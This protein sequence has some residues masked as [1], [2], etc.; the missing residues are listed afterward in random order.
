MEWNG[1]EGKVKLRINGL[2]IIIDKWYFI[3]L[4]FLRGFMKYILELFIWKIKGR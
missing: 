4:D 2:V 1:E 3:L